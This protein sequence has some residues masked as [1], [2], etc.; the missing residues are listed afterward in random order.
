MVSGFSNDCLPCSENLI[1]TKYPSSST[2]RKNLDNYT[3][4]CLHK[5]PCHPS[6]W[7][8][9]KDTDNQWQISQGGFSLVQFTTR[10]KWSLQ[11]WPWKTS[12]ISLKK[13][14]LA[15]AIFL[16]VDATAYRLYLE[17]TESPSTER[18]TLE[19]NISPEPTH[20][21]FP[22]LSSLQ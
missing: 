9:P 8:R 11:H 19:S 7:Q 20:V 17:Q 21:Q 15:L 10:F 2:D 18:F 5:A 3:N 4:L 1:H 14:K 16:L 22:P 13:L 12:V 6:D